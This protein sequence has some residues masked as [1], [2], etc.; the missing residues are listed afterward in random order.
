MAD[1]YLCPEDQPHYCANKGCLKK[2]VECSNTAVGSG[3]PGY[4]TTETPSLQMIE[5]KTV[6]AQHLFNNLDNIIEWTK[7]DGLQKKEIIRFCAKIGDQ[8]FW[9]KFVLGKNPNHDNMAYKLTRNELIFFKEKLSNFTPHIVECAASRINI[10]GYIESVD[11]SQ[12]Q[13]IERNRIISKINTAVKNNADS[14]L[15][16]VFYMQPTRWVYLETFMNVEEKFHVTQL[17]VV[18]MLFQ[19][20]YTIACLNSR[21]LIHGKLNEKKTIV[22]DLLPEEKTITY[23][24]NG[25]IYDIPTRHKV[26]IL[27]WED[28]TGPK[29]PKIPGSTTIDEKKDIKDVCE[30]FRKLIDDVISAIDLSFLDTTKFD[31]AD[32]FLQSPIFKT[33]L[34]LK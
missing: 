14:V 16:G 15:M 33:F 32:Q 11:G 20:V 9:A 23:F 7:D 21:K 18:S 6:N 28:V 30:L 31:T 34:R 29:I 25:V 19:I 4:K 17:M 1:N 12:S 27:N 13:Y 26:I 8:C 22:L 3:K 10:T 5:Q 2:I 24:R